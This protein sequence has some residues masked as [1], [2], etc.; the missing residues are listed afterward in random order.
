VQFDKQSELKNLEKSQYKYSVPLRGRMSLRNIEEKN[1]IILKK[2]GP[3]FIGRDGANDLI[4]PDDDK[5]SRTHCKLEVIENVPYLCDLGSTYGTFLG[6]ERI[7][8]APLKPDDI[9]LVGKTK[10]LFEVKDAETIFSDGN[11]PIL[12]IDQEEDKCI[13]S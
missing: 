3:W 11:R 6:E 9:F 5:L 10:L 2:D 12:A 13:I 7:T 8:L 4:I 1:A